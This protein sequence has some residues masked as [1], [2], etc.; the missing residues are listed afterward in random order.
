MTQPKKPRKTPAKKSGPSR[1]AVKEAIEKAEDTSEKSKPTELDTPEQ[2]PVADSTESEPPEAKP[3]LTEP[4]LDD[5]EL[6]TDD[7]PD[8]LEDHVQWPDDIVEDEVDQQEVQ[9]R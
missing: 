2:E 5:D 7:L 4:E 3:D 8:E 1:K 6:G 9:R